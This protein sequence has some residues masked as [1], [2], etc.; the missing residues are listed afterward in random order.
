MNKKNYWHIDF[1]LYYAQIEKAYYKEGI[2]RE[3]C[4]VALLFSK[5]F[6][7]V[8]KFG[9]SDC[10]CTSHLFYGLK[11]KFEKQIEKLDFR[12]FQQ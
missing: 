6:S 5:S 1:F 8:P 12:L 3:E 10:N 9:C 11:E 4:K 7:I 2:I